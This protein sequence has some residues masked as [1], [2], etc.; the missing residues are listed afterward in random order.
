MQRA[1]APHRRARWQAEREMASK[2]ALG[3]VAELKEKA[4]SNELFTSC[5]DLYLSKI[6]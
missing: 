5:M 1:A 2:V 4:R 6:Q 3:R